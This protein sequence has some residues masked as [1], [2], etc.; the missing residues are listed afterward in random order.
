MRPNNYKYKYIPQDVYPTIVLIKLYVC[1][2]VVLARE[3]MMT[4]SF[5]GRTLTK[6]EHDRRRGPYQSPSSH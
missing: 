4:A 1:D 3:F 5:K 2:V 6:S